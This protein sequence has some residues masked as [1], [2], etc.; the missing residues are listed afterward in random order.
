MNT[1]IVEVEN[2]ITDTSGLVTTPVLNTKIGEVINKIPDHAKYITAP[3]FKKSD[4][5]V[6]DTKLDFK[7][8]NNE[9]KL[10]AGKSKGIYTSKL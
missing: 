9:Y 8:E 4:G 10:S 6:C 7:Q 3:E 2:K 1:K 5:S